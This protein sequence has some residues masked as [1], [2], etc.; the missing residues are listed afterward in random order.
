MSR[1]RAGRRHANSWINRSRATI[2]FAGLFFLV[3]AWAGSLRL[4]AT[5]V[6]RFSIQELSLRSQTIVQGVVKGSRTFW[7]PDR[8]LI[9]TSTILEVTESLK[10]QTGRTIEVTTVGGQVGETVLHVSGMPAFTAGENAILFIERSGQF[11]TVLGLSQGKFT[12]SNGQAGNS[13][14]GLNFADG[15]TSSDTRLPLQSLKDAIR[16][17]LEQEKRK[18]SGR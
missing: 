4:F 13:V 15:A 5:T 16:S 1:C 2:G 9:L 17:A 7:S 6:E 10:G 11:L 8:K 3:S 12:V 18:G 14:S